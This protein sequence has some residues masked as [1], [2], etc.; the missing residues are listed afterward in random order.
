MPPRH[1]YMAMWLYKRMTKKKRECNTRG[2]C[3]LEI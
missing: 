2:Y 3:T 1:S